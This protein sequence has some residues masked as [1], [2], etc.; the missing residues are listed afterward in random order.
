MTNILR[1]R[2]RQTGAAGPPPSLYA[3]ELAFNEVDNT[4]YYG[5]GNDGADPPLAT[6]V[7]AVA[8]AGA[9]SGASVLV[10]DTPPTGVPDNSLWWESDTGGLYILFNDGNTSQWVQVNSQPGSIGEAPLDGQAYVRQSGGWAV[11]SGAGGGGGVS[12]AP[13]DGYLYAR[14]NSAW[15]SAGDFNG[16]ITF[17]GGT[18]FASL[19][20]LATASNAYASQAN[21]NFAGLGGYC[22]FGGSGSIYSIIGYGSYSIY[23]SGLA[24]FSS[25][26]C[27]TCTFN[28]STTTSSAT[29]YLSTGGGLY[30]STSSVEFKTSIEPLQPEFADKVLAL[31]TLFYRPGENTVDPTDWSRFGFSVEN[32]YAVDFRFTVCSPVTKPIMIERPLPDP[33]DPTKTKMVLIPSGEFETVVESAP[34]DIDMKAIVACLLDVVRRQGERIAALEAARV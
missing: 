26:E 11:G 7:I 32:A 1:T 27:P 16:S 10:A 30:R 9:G 14:K 29:A 24:H 21:Y 13:T 25:M 6:A 3:S 33:D 8:T 31:D 12:E 5:K 15:A 23:A 28:V 34:S 20:I 17:R 2:R 19:N 4:L 18:S 22:G